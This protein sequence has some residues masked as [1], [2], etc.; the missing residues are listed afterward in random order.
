[1]VWISR[2]VSASTM[3]RTKAQPLQLLVLVPL[4]QFL[5]FLSSILVDG[6]VWCNYTLLANVACGPCTASVNWVLLLGN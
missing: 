6:L 5:K 2:N 1:M 3:L 4:Q